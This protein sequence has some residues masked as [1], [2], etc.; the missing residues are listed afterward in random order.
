M[1]SAQLGTL[2]WGPAA[3]SPAS[4]AWPIYLHTAGQG[5]LADELEKQSFATQTRL[6]CLG[7]QVKMD[8]KD[9]ETVLPPM[10][11]VGTAEEAAPSGA[12]G[13]GWPGSSRPVFP[14]PATQRG[15]TQSSSCFSAHLSTARATS[16]PGRR[17]LP[18]NPT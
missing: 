3:A 1:P 17:H 18:D 16:R 4:S 14:N 13:D 15:C 7:R 5:E 2:P 9:P 11:D 8:C 10:D 12:R 6:I